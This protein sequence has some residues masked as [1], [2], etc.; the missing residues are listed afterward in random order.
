M[1]FPLGVVRL[2][3]DSSVEVSQ[4][5]VS[6]VPSFLDPYAKAFLTLQGIHTRVFG[7]TTSF[8]TTAVCACNYYLR[9]PKHL[10][11]QTSRAQY[12]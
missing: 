10:K 7:A 11:K 2:H 9:Q 8:S 6:A 3:G 12:C 5:W 4:L 1:A